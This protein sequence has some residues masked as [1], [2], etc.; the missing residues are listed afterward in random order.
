MAIDITGITNENEFY[1]HHYLSAILENDLK[2]VFSQWKQREEE[3]ERPQPHT[4]LRSL[5]KDFFAK[6]S[7]LEKERDI[8]ERISIQRDFAERLL[9]GLGYEYNTEIVDL[10]DES[11][12]PLIGVIKKGD[13]FPALWILEAVNTFGEDA[14]PLELHFCVEQYPDDNEIQKVLDISMEEIIT[15]QVF[16][17]SEPPRWVFLNSFNQIVLLDRTKW[18]EKRL[19]RFDVREILDRR[20]TS[21]LQAMAALLH[22][23]SI[24]PKDGMPLLDTLDEN[25]H[26]HAFA[27]SEDLKYS[28]REAIELLGNEAVYYLREHLHEK[29]YGRDMAGQ[30]TRECLR[31]MYRM[32][33]LFYIE[34]RPE[35]G[36]LPDKSPEYRKGYSL[37]SLRNL[38]MIK[39]TTEESKNGFYFHESIN[40]LF[41]LLYNGF[42][43]KQLDVFGGPDHHTFSISPLRSHLFDPRKTPLLNRVKFR[44]FVLQRIIELMSLSRPKR[45]RKNRRGRISYSQLGINQLGAVYEALLS[46]Q[47]FFAET[48]LY[49]VKKAGEK[50]NV[51]ETAYFVKPEDLE[52]YT[53][54]E[55]VF[56]DDGTLAKYDKGTFI[57]RLAGRDREK[58][59][60]YYTPEVL[61]KCL[62][63]YALKELLKDKTADEILELTVCEPAMGSAAFLNEAVN[64]L[65][66]AYLELKQKEIGETISHDDY[67]RELQKVKMYIADNNVHGVDLNPVAVELAEVSL[68]LNTI[69]EGGFVPWFGMQLVCGNSLIG[70][71]RQVFHENL[72]KRKE[73]KDP[74]WLDEVPIRVM[75]GE[76]RKNDAIYHFLL[77]DKGMADYKD[78]VI[79]QMAGDEIKTINEWR[80]E[81]TK[82]F[83][84]SE[85]S[86]LKKLS[87]AVDKLWKRHAEMQR[88][89]EERTTDS[90][91]VFGQKEPKTSPQLTTTE[92]KDR[93][94]EQE[95]FSKNVRNSGPYRRLKLVMD[96]WCALWFWPIEKADLLPSRAEFLFDITLVLEGNLY[97]VD[98]DEEGQQLLFPD[99]SP[100]QMSL[101]MLDEFG[102]VN[103]DKLCQENK[104]LGLVKE[105]AER[106]R[107]LHWEMEF[108]ELFE[109]RG[110]FDLVLGNPPW[111]KAEWNESGVLGDAEPLFAVRKFS[112]SKLAEL[113]NLTLKKYN[114]QREYLA[115]Y[116]EMTGMIV[117]LKSLQ[118]YRVLEGTQTNIF[119]CFIPTSLYINNLKQGVTTFVTDQ[120]IY[121]DP[122]GKML[123]SFCYK[124]LRYLFFF[125]NEQ[126]LFKEVG[127]EKKF[128]VV[129]FGP[130]RNEITFKVI[131][132][133][134][135]PKAIDTC[136]SHSGRGQ[137]PG[138][139]NEKNEWE[140]TGHRDR[141]INIDL[142]ILELFAKV[143][144]DSDTISFHARLPAIHSLQA[145]NVI[146]KFG[147]QS[148]RLED[149]AGEYS[150]TVMWDETNAQRKKIIKRETRF[151]N[152]SSQLIISGPHIYV[153]NPFHQTPKAICKT[154]RAYDNIDLS[155]I[156]EN[157]L[158]R[159]NYI[160]IC[161][162]KIYRDRTPGVAWTK[163]RKVTEFYRLITR[164]M[165][166]HSA[167]R[168]LISAIIPPEVSHI[169][170]CF[171]M[172]FHNVKSLAEVA[173]TFVSLPYDFY[174]RNLGK[175]NFL[176]DSAK[177]LPI[178]GGYLSSR[179]VLR[180][181]M[182]TCI[183]SHYSDIW[184]ECWL[185][186]NRNEKWAKLDSRLK[187]ERFISLTRIWHWNHA[188]R[189]A[190][191]RRQMLLEIDVLVAMALGLGLD[192]LKTIYRI[193]FPVL[194][195]NERDTWYDRN[196]RIVFTCSKGLIGVGFSRPEWNDIKEMQS[197]TVER[198]VIDDT[199]P[200]GP[201]E[202][203]ITYEAPF[204]RCDREKD[205]EVV[206]A[207]FE[208]RF[209]EQKGKA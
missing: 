163:N 175:A 184:Q 20:E 202:R 161:K 61:T 151:P 160:P 99:T 15:R 199:M 125:Q 171:S 139:K 42:E 1:T 101:K 100:K 85:I 173:S 127:N 10:D 66:K 4:R 170:G 76:K 22:R 46:Y 180:F 121:N 23:D 45:G 190:Y 128:E 24:C 68:W 103:V 92:F 40:T 131:A 206:W 197:G 196:G 86:Q 187:E 182:L 114:I 147:T 79:K 84:K 179:I 107:F 120:G 115:E 146:R 192:E 50:H 5:R 142:G 44:N 12:I 181:L 134:F 186:R 104:R 188:V 31:Y 87:N 207:E 43:P 32:L 59:A 150:A 158:P 200:G 89:I 64:Q 144:D 72:L 29:V 193:Q 164:K 98:V 130:E 82:P 112:S 73:R 33:F 7:L 145:V 108:A 60:S 11:R 14:D 83:T 93:I 69:Y 90:L 38:E 162:P 209:K 117:F 195:Q 143:Y 70:A 201:I 174:V 16:G 56:N 156:P 47:G 135:H 2:E 96:Y 140:L 159:T 205:Y 62:V 26:K 52:Q 95:M 119:K 191:E 77:P 57:Y 154:H 78:E 17:R 113:R 167:E 141:I 109:S 185:E 54:D 124:R 157:Y 74:F 3:E 65:S 80:K 27:V 183:T 189:S 8:E 129:V 126:K 136:F 34:A 71:R 18:H 106:Y 177:H 35:L 165:L 169:H 91:H 25:S 88:H 172:A 13:G 36:Y 63:K 49:E 37:E 166:N 48:D 81:F 204:D 55:R 30:L 19:L 208:G 148:K 97:E 67:P 133:L 51:L 116:I 168:S 122:H 105:L 152:N 28:L 118:N 6:I 203:T 111:I 198:I 123:R 39:L 53:E 137:V 21:T 58:S 110:G 194:L 178:I 75:P 153:G 9:S 138:I 132:N 41:D 94:F 176:E 102:Y 155:N 149:N